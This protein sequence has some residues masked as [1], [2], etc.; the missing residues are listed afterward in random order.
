MD[1]KLSNMRELRNLVDTME[2]MAREGELEGTEIFLFTNNSTAQDTF[3][4]GSSKSEGLFKLVLRVQRLEMTEQ[5][6]LH[7]CHVTGMRMIAQGADGLSRGNLT[8]GVMRGD[9]ML[10]FIPIHQTA[11]ERRPQLKNWLESWVSEDVEFLEPK[12][13][14]VR[15]HG[16]V[17]GEF[18]TNI[19]NMI[20]PQMRQGKFIWAP[21]PAAAG[22]CV[23]ELRQARHT[24]QEATHLSV[25]PRLMEPLWRKDL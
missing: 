18:E 3:A 25:V 13:W 1:D 17:E 20:W 8:E 22:V 5:C 14:F 4:N 2:R 6:K 11:L 7:V 24:N 10:H 16:L 19:D 12:D 21:A 9:D 23:Q 15:G